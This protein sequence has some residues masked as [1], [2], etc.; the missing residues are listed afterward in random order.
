[1][2]HEADLTAY[3]IESVIVLI[4]NNHED[5]VGRCNVDMKKEHKNYTIDELPHYHYGLFGCLH[6]CLILDIGIVY[7]R[8]SQI[9]GV[10][11]A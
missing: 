6:S 9:P 10:W 7:G 3:D 8:I 5:E 11:L 4:S 2:L 1:V